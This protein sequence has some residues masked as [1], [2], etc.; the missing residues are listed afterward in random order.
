[1]ELAF[2]SK[3]VI[4]FLTPTHASFI[5][6]DEKPENDWVDKGVIRCPRCYLLNALKWKFHNPEKY[7]FRLIIEE[8][9][10]TK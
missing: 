3:D 7:R 2:L 4:N 1:M 6:N 8:V 9:N 5:C 10:G